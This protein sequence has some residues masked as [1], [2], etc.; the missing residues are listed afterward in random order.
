MTYSRRQL[1]AFGEPL[2][3]SVTRAKPGG[4]IYG[5]G[6]GGSAAPTSQTVTQTSIPEYARPYVEKLLGRVE[7]LT[8]Q[9]YNPYTGQRIAGFDPMQLQAQQAV[10][11]LQASRQLGIGTGIT[12]TAAQRYA[13]F[14]TP[15][16]F[17]V[18][19]QMA[20]LA[21]QRAANLGP[22]EQLGTATQLAGLAALRAG[23]V[24]YDPAEIRNQQVRNAF[25]QQYQMQGPETIYT[26]S[27]TEPGVSSQYMSPYIQEALN[28]QL[29]EARRQ[30]D[31]S[32]QQQKAAAVGAGAYGGS[33]Q[34]I[35]EAERQRNLGQQL[36]DIQARGMQT[37]YEQAQG[38]Y[39][40]EAAR[41]LQAAQANQQMGYQTGLQNLQALLNIQN[42]AAQQG[43]TSQQLNQQA[44]LEAQKAAEQSRQF[45]AGLSMQG[46]QTQLQGAGQLANIGQIQGQQER[47]AINTLLA[48]SGQMGQL[49]QM[50]GQQRLAAL[51]GLGQMGA[52]MGQ[53]GQAEFGQQKD[54]INALNTTGAQRQGLEQMGLDQQYQEFMR[55]QQYPYQQAAFMSDI[56][57]GLPLTQQSQSIYAPL[58]PMQTFLAGS[59]GVG[60]LKQAGV[61]AKGGSV[62]ESK[63][64]GLGALALHQLG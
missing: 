56:L 21:G 29:R 51:A 54:I 50:Q 33:R 64:G 45:G 62:E 47:D 57:R 39:G 9:E 32:A 17:D 11:N 49:G 10:A 7:A 46:L 58:S 34:A 38:L 63:G 14:A 61:F 36:G 24:Q 35:I 4:R 19:T 27:F 6:G 55:Q 25:L 15:E 52:Q 30:S 8:G 42:L 31:I 53:L 23:N 43:L 3:E 16:Q 12:G 28:P 2:G 37:A 1:E 5:G 40:T 13:D 48:S 60:G 41:A 26:G 20:G 22:A 44:N 59:L 18:G